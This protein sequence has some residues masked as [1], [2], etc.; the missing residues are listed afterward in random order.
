MTI[1]SCSQ[2]VYAAFYADEI[3][4]GL[5]HGHTYSAN[6]LACAAAL[7]GIELLNSEEIQQDISRVTKYHQEFKTK[8]KKHPKVRN[9]RQL[10]VILAFELD[11]KM[12]RYGEVR[13]KLFKHFMDSGVF[14]RPLGN[15]IYILAPYVI[16]N[17]ELEKIYQSIE[18]ALEKF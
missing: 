3:A 5:F 13:N 1:T 16:S 6:P 18:T 7:A 12:E 8:L 11:V 14:L 17:K 9:I 4:K 15:T 10:G 2:Q